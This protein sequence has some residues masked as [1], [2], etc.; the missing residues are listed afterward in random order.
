MPTS[1]SLLMIEGMS[2]E[3]IDR[4]N[5]I[6]IENALVLSC[7]NPFMLW[8]RLPFDLSLV[9]EWVAQAQ[10]YRW[11]KENGIEALRKAHINNVF[12][13]YEHLSDTEARALTC[14][15]VNMDPRV[16][17]AFLSAL[18]HD[19]AFD[20]LLEVRV[21]LAVVPPVAPQEPVVVDLDIRQ[22]ALAA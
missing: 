19:P 6:G 4:L 20:R 22:Q 2:R 12:E 17:K 13:L 9:V 11:V 5:E 3:K 21:A 1:L 15:V 8:T 16:G 18:T 10:L 14:E 7:Q